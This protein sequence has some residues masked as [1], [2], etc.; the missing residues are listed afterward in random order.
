MFKVGETELQ[1]IQPMPGSANL[2]TTKGG[3]RLAE[4]IAIYAWRRQCRAR[5]AV[6]VFRCP[7]WKYMQATFEIR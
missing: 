7:H 5:G 2:F 3:E 1:F 4:K 6:E